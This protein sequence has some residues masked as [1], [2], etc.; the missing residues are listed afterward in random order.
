MKEKWLRT[1]LILVLLASCSRPAAPAT[2]QAGT[3]DSIQERIA[4]VENGLIPMTEEGQLAGG[5]PRALLER[6]SYYGVPGLSIAVIHNYE[7]EWARGY[8]VLE[9]GGA[10]P[11]AP[12]TLFNAGSIMKPLC[13]AAAL[14]LVQQ[15]LL[16]LDE[17]VNEKMVSW[18]VPENAYTVEQKVTPRRLLSHSAG[19]SDGFTNRSP[20]DREP[21]YVVSAGEAPTVTVQE[22]LEAAP[23]VDV[24]GPT[25]VTRVPGSGYAYANADYAILKLLLED[26]TGRPFAEWMDETVLEPLEM[27]SSTYE[28]PL[29]ENLRARATTEHYA[30]GEPFAGKR[31]HYP[32]GGLWSTP[33]DLARFAIELSLAYKGQ[34]GKILSQPMVQEMLS[35]QIETPGDLLGDSFGLGLQLAGEGRALRFFHTGGTWGSTCVLWMYPET[36]DGAVVMTNS[37]AAQGVIRFEILLGI[38]QEYGWPLDP[39]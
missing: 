15:G 1:V 17:D 31:H 22:M 8:G 34:S 39:T 27:T 20:M 13:A 33:S 30:S 7:I 32:I 12:D 19:L 23:G 5:E 24:D 14:E 35:S 6:M 36:G 26:V 18:R 38:A 4:R 16:G 3:R 28:Q 21:S 29:P 25:L 37:A 9:A 10:E 2:P 11:V